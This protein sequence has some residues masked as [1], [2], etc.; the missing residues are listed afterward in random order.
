MKQSREQLEKENTTLRVDNQRLG[1]QDKLL[2]ADFAKIL[3][4]YDI[5]ED[6]WTHKQDRALKNPSWAE[7]FAELGRLQSAR[8]FYDLE[9]NVSEL[10]CKLED[11]EKR[12][13]KNVNPNL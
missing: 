7:I 1:E 10:E 6:K 9:G 12:L 8:T 3:N 11:L 5:Y 2:R 4:W 13:L